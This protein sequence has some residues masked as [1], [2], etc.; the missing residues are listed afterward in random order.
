M[1]IRNLELCTRRF[2]LYKVVEFIAKTYSSNVPIYNSPCF[3]YNWQ[4]GINIAENLEGRRGF[5]YPGIVQIRKSRIDSGMF[6][7]LPLHICR[8]LIQP[9]TR[10]AHHFPL[11]ILKIYP[12]DT[13]WKG[14]T[15]NFYPK[16][17]GIRSYC[18]RIVEW[19]GEVVT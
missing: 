18:C 17:N 16:F 15:V 7:F 12:Q 6:H 8:K 5:D 9:S 19:K 4:L 10:F 2:P 3:G 13:V 14:N 11:A 1:C